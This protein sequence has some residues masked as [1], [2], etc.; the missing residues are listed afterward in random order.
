MT[1]I[2]EQ[3][4]LPEPPREAAQAYWPTSKQLVAL[5]AGYFALQVFL[6]VISSNSV[7]LDES[8][9][10]VLSQKFSWGYA[11]DPPL[12]IWLQMLLF[13]V[14][15]T[16]VL[17]L[18]LLKNLLLFSTYVLTFATARLVT[19]SPVAGVAA[20]LSLFYIPSIAWESQRDLTHSVLSAT[21]SVATLFSFL[22]LQDTR[23]LR[24][25]IGFG[26]CAG[27]GCISK[28]NY[29]LW[30]LGLLLAGFVLNATRSALLN[31]RLL[32]SAG[33][34]LLI[35]LPSG[36]WMLENRD[37]AL[38]TSS[39]LEFKQSLSWIQ[40]TGLGLKNLVQSMISFTA[41][42]SLIY[43]LLFSRAPARMAPPAAERPAYRQLIFTS[44]AIIGFV[45][46]LLVVF[47][48]A[49][50]F[51][52]RWFQP[53]LVMLPIAAVALVQARLDP[54]RLK[55]ITGLTL[56]VMVAVA[57]VMPGR[58]L[59]AERLKR[60]EPLT[61]P[62]AQIAKAIRPLVPPDSLLLCD[63]K[64]LAGNLRLGTLHATQLYIELLPLFRTNYTHCF[65]VWDARRND[66]PPDHLS[67]WAEA[68][69]AR[70][71][72]PTKPRFFTESY[73]YHRSKVFRIGCLQLY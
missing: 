24:W 39:K 61:R 35:F 59:V 68:H 57:T 17:A 48:R 66:A 43:L 26:L 46:V 40:V 7:D 13:R 22:K 25:Y 73:R 53:I 9:A 4:P 3:A 12:Y 36:L 54:L 20:A 50:G 6:R 21:L 69:G 37:L 31:P 72:T 33:I 34:A 62:Y 10:V 16:S 5:L 55:W 65:L 30:L 18:S 41:P 32:L 8:E 58:L 67:L 19:R 1:M 63:S 29:V 47:A 49:T 42:L 56:V 51:K 44:W 27:F 60:E 23:G 38:L 28:F 52:E 2:P 15:G 11:T 70:G 14:F 71:P 64:L 45:L